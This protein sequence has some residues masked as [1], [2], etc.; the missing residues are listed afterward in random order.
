M[1][2]CLINHKDVTFL[3]S[4][5]VSKIKPESLQVYRV[6]IMLDNYLLELPVG[7]FIVLI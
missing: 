3:G 1:S 4:G 2:W 7:L 6:F 5:H